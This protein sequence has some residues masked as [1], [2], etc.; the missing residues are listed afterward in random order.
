MKVVDEIFEESFQ[1]RDE[2]SEQEPKYQL[3]TLDAGWEQIR[4]MVY[5]RDAYPEAKKS[6]RLSKLKAEF[7]T[8]LRALGDKIAE[9]Y[10]QDTGF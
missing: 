5:G 2:Y 9:R 8:V 1:Y 6:E 4:R 7:D 10:S 3:N